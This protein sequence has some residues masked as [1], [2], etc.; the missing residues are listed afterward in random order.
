MRKGDRA[1]VLVATLLRKRT[2][3]TNDW[4]AQRLSMGHH[5]SVSRLVVA[6]SKDAKHESELKKLMR[7]LKCVT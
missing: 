1:K 3:A 7:M 5:G 4:I 2:A 6:A